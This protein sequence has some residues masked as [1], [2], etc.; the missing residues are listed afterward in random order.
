MTDNIFMISDASY[1]DTTKCAGLGVID[2]HTGQKY[3][4][5]LCKMK[6]SHVAEYRALCLS[7]RIAIQ[8]NY[9]NVVFVYDNQ[10]LKLDTLKLWLLDKIQTYQFLWLKR[11]YVDDADKLARKARTLQEKLIANKT[12]SL[13]ISDDNILQVLKTYPKKKILRACMKI[14]NKEE[15]V[16]L[17]THIKDEKYPPVLVSENS[18]DFYSDVYHLLSKQ[19]AK[20]QKSYLKFI[21]KNYSKNIDIDKFLRAKPNEYYVVLVH[22]IVSKLTLPKVKVIKEGAKLGDVALISA[23]KK[24]SVRGISDF[25]AVIGTKDDK[26]LLNGYFGGKKVDVHT[27]N[28]NGIKLYM[29]IHSLLPQ[30]RKNNFYRFIKNRIQDATLERRFVK[31]NNIDFQTTM[32]NKIIELKNKA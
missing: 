23:I 26:R 16:I 14:A 19:K 30:D 2:L 25:C 7:V 1:S 24:Y 6:N 15:S 5:S 10:S 12:P 13:V 3:S 28:N 31:S 32:I 22:K 11:A 4:H 18:I 17:N 21:D 8:N 9:D 29:L 27:F 20:A